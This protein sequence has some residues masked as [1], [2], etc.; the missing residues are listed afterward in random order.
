MDVSGHIVA[1]RNG[2]TAVG[3][4]NPTD[5]GVG[6]E[7]ADGMGYKGSAHSLLQPPD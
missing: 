3:M 4:I 7:R 1:Q 5:G 6:M 2:N